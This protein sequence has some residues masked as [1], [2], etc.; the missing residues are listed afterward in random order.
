MLMNTVDCRFRIAAL[1]A[2]SLALGGF[3]NSAAAQVSEYIVFSGD[4]STFSVIQDGQL[5]RS[6]GVAVNSARYQYPL[7]I[8]QTIRTMGA[9]EGD[10]GAEYDLFGGDLGSRYT[11][12]IGQSRCW[13]GTTSGTENFAIDSG[14]TVARYDSNWTSPII[15]FDA[16]GIGAVTYDPT[17][18]SLWV[19]QFSGTT[20]VVEYD[21]RGT[22]LRSINVGHERNMALALDHADGTLWLHDRG[23]RGTFEQWTKGGVLLTRRSIVGMEGQ[24]ALAG[25]FQLDQP[26]Y[27]D[28]DGRR[29]GHLRLPLLPERLRGRVPIDPPTAGP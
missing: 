11:H 27:A 1:I 15:L 26:C 4:Q 25:E 28:C 17:N 16:G 3:A 21:M 8:N 7:A 23:Q 18:D 6:W 29:A 24:N 20:T 9:N 2:G 14:G 22:V 19:S 13:D 12:P 5:I 10:D